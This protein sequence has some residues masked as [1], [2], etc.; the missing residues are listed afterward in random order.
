MW[1][2]IIAAVAAIVGVIIQSGSNKDLAEYQADRNEEYLKQ[3]QDYDSPKSQMD[4]F[5]EAGLNPSLMY[6]QG[7]TGN[8]GA[9]LSFPNINPTD[10]S[11]AFRSVGQAGLTALQT[12]IMNAELMQKESKAVESMARTGLI[13]VQTEIAKNNP[14]LNPAVTKAMGESWISAA[15][16]KAS[17]A[18]LAKQKS[19][20]ATKTVK[21]IDEF[22]TYRNQS[23]GYRKMIAELETLEQKYNLGRADQKIKGE[24]LESKEFQNR[25]QEIQVRFMEDGDLTPAHFVSFIQLLLMKLASR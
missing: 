8:M 12:R 7:S 23:N 20:F 11:G 1:A 9:P 10:F 13:E 2:A 22:G 21:G 17:E 25:L 3:Q 15:Q 6:G 14:Q 24:V 4:R 19:D 18:T 16:I 5:S